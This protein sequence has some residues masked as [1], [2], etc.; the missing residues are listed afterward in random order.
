M[1]I[2]NKTASFIISF[3]RKNSSLSETDLV[4][5]D[6]GIKVIVSNFIKFVIL[7]TTAYFL[8]IIKYTLFSIFV[9]GF[10]RLFASGVHASS[11]LECIILNYTIF[12]GI[13]YLSLYTKLPIWLII[14][15]FIISVFLLILYSPA[16]TKTR[17]LISKKLRKSLKIKSIITCLILFIVSLSIKSSVYKNLITYSVFMA[18]FVITPLCYK[19]FRQPYNNYLNFN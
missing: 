16:D 6:Y 14:I 1:F 4:K 17:P 13:V 9:F 11:T 10:I 8:N 19:I 15:I 5:I 3:L 12:F 7:I 2:T 18:C